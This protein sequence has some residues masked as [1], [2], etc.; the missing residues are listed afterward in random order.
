[1]SFGQEM[2]RSRILLV[3]LFLNIQSFNAFTL[4]KRHSP[5]FQP[6]PYWRYQDFAEKNDLR[7]PGSIGVE[8]REPIVRPLKKQ[9]FDEQLKE[10]LGMQTKAKNHG[11]VGVEIREPIVWTPN[12]QDSAKQNEDLEERISLLIRAHS[13]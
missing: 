9:D 10:D 6:N 2:E 13:F 5:L 1:M 7:K 3:F 8:I 12:Y 11:L 4:K